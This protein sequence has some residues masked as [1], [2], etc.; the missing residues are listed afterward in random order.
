MEEI[1]EWL[2]NCNISEEKETT[3]YSLERRVT[4]PIYSFLVWH[5]SF[6]ML[7]TGSCGR[8]LYDFWLSYFI[9]LL[10]RRGRASARLEKA[11]P[12]KV[13]QSK[14]VRFLIPVVPSVRKPTTIFKTIK[15]SQPINSC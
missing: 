8:A 13:K 7:R 1:K 6:A 10:F 3:E 14:Q 2:K 5:D 12:L 9:Y 15:N 11:I 4:I